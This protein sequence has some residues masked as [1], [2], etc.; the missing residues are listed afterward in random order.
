MNSRSLCL[1]GRSGNAT[2]FDQN[3]KGRGT[4]KDCFMG[5]E[6]RS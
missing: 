1:G 2:G 6:E 4:V 3:R 5:R